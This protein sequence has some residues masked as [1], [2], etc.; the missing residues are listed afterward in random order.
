MFNPPPAG[1]HTRELPIYSAPITK[2]WCRSHRAGYDPVY[3]GK[4]KAQRWDAPK[5]DYGV[6]YLGADE[7]CA[8]MESIGRG[9][10]KTRLVPAAQLRIRQCRVWSISGTWLADAPSGSFASMANADLRSV[11]QLGPRIR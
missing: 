7:R 6:L 10:L 1:L 11:S 2:V 8:F 5:G 3:F 4:N 9:V